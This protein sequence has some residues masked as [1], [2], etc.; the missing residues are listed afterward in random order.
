MLFSE[1]N[2]INLNVLI[3]DPDYEVL[4]SLRIPKI[5]ITPEHNTVTMYS[6]GNCYIHNMYD[7]RV[8]YS[9]PVDTL[10]IDIS[11]NE[12]ERDD[13]GWKLS[14]IYINPDESLETKYLEH[15]FTDIS[16]DMLYASDISSDVV[17]IFAGAFDI[18]GTIDYSAFID[19][20]DIFDLCDRDSDNKV[21]HP[22]F[23]EH[24]WTFNNGAFQWIG[25]LKSIPEC[26][27]SY[28]P[29]FDSDPHHKD[30]NH[31]ML[32]DYL[33]FSVIPNL[34]FIF[35]T[36]HVLK[37]IVSLPCADKDLIRIT[38]KFFEDF[39][40]F[41]WQHFNNK[42][43][44]K[45]IYSILKEFC[46]GSESFYLPT[47]RIAHPY[48]KHII[49]D[50]KEVVFNLLKNPNVPK[51]ESYK[52]IFKNDN[53]LN[54]FLNNSI[55]KTFTVN[56]S[57]AVSKIVIDGNPSDLD[58]LYSHN[59]LYDTMEHVNELQNLTKKIFAEYEYTNKF[60]KLTEKYLVESSDGFDSTALMTLSDLFKQAKN[61]KNIFD[62]YD[63]KKDIPLHIIV[64]PEKLCNKD[65]LKL[66][67]NVRYV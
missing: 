31:K 55:W 52:Y 1:L 47:I 64:L 37:G 33:R 10:T 62:K 14:P 39:I 11:D 61:I 13:N 29:F 58:P 12:D 66:I 57:F 42:L 30:T 41:V 4:P 36:Q 46:K 32:D 7:W 53:N 3:Q 25:G 44:F 38:K 20:E 40:A 54:T 67:S 35:N 5:E 27:F 9:S 50:P 21:K 65:I 48:K 15:A 56:P 60:T 2:R 26:R 59:T 18:D 22:P 16:N 43:T 28:G 6:D 19:N 51:A 17:K 24:W 63:D 49:D 34:H 23:R 8:W 45:T